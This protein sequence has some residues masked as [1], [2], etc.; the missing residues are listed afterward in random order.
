MKQI[1]TRVNDEVAEALKCQALRSG[2]SV[3]AYMNRLLRV[4]VGDT[5]SSRQMWKAAAVADGRLM[6]RAAQAGRTR[7]PAD[8][9]FKTVVSTPAG[10]A[11]R[12]VSAER[13]EN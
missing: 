9:A 7:S 6:E 3:N 10:Y 12:V 13:D 8:L 11:S 1:I 2:E 5:T 4:V